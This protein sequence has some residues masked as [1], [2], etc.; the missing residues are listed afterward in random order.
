MSAQSAPNRRR[1]LAVFPAAAGVLLAAGETLTPKGLDNTTSSLAGARKEI[2]I[3][4]VHAH[5]F[6]AA[7]LLI[8][9]GLAALGIAFSSLVALMNRPGSKRLSAIALVGWFATLC[10]VISNSALNY[11][12]AAAGAVKSGAT[13]ANIFLQE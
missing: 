11:G 1:I 4:T 8:I 7:S 3:A 2:V 6:Y 12:L 5:R 9:F 13:G 10:G